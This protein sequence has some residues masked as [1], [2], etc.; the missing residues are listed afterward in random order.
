M[1]SRR[2]HQKLL[3]FRLNDKIEAEKKLTHKINS[4][5]GIVSSDELTEMCLKRNNLQNDINTLTKQV[6][7]L[8]NGKCFL[9]DVVKEVN[10]SGN[11]HTL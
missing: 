11:L 8:Q 6:V 10:E 3:E 7:N 9:G 4:S 1:F 5:I 2:Q